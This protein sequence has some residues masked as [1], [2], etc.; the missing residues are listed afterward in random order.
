[1]NALRTGRR[2]GRRAWHGAF[3]L[4]EIIL[5][6]AILA[7][8]L[9]VMGEVMRLAV[10]NAESARQLTQAELL[11]ESKLGEITAG[12]TLADPVQDFPFELQPDWTYTIAVDLTDDVG[13]VSVRITVAEAEA[14]GRQPL[15]YMLVRWMLDPNVE[16]SRST[17]SGSASDESEDDE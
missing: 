11:A 17:E 1:M 10:R 5:A 13:L 9:A 4:L 3:T 15:E 6:L 16:F 2:R 8:S 7:G 14:T 12:I